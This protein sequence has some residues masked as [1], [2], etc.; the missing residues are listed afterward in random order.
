MALR[1]GAEAKAPSSACGTSTPITEQKLQALP[2][3]VAGAVSVQFADDFPYFHPQRQPKPFLLHAN[4]L[5]AL[6]HLC[7]LRYLS[8]FWIF[9]RPS[10]PGPSQSFLQPFPPHSAVSCCEKFPF[11]LQLPP[12]ASTAPGVVFPRKHPPHLQGHSY[13]SLNPVMQETTPSPVPNP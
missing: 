1:D 7:T 2:S 10:H 4:P 12:T 6:E 8:H 11:Q 5:F 3:E 9:I 13:F